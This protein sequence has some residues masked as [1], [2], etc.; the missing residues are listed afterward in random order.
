[1][2]ASPVTASA[3]SPGGEREGQRQ[4]EEGGPAQAAQAEIGAHGEP[5][6]AGVH[7]A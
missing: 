7:Q 3:V 4:Q 1:M 2:C 6:P 5:L